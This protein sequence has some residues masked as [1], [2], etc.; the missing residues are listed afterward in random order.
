MH[1][2]APPDASAIFLHGNLLCKDT[3]SVTEEYKTYS[4]STNGKD[5]AIVIIDSQ[6]LSEVLD[7]LDET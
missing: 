5:P 6:K 3:C 2:F 1:I 4:R 7:I